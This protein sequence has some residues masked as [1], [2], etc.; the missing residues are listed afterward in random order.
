MNSRRPPC[1][2]FIVEKFHRYCV[3]VSST[4]L[5]LLSR[6]PFGYLPP[7]ALSPYRLIASSPLN[8]AAVGVP[9]RVSRLPNPPPLH[10]FIPRRTCRVIPASIHY[11]IHLT[12]IKWRL[13]R[14]SFLCPLSRIAFGYP[15]VPATCPVLR[16]RPQVFLVFPIIWFSSRGYPRELFR[17]SN[18]LLYALKLSQ[19]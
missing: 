15:Y 5:C 10:P 2:C 3:A 12:P 17:T 16:F 19:S 9:S 1:G 7:I 8:Y 11:T 4:L 14:P 18:Q 6:I 13:F